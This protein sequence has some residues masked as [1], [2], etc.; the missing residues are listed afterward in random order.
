MLPVFEFHHNPRL[1]RSYPR[2]LC[3]TQ[4][5]SPVAP[6]QTRAWRVATFTMEPGQEKPPGVLES[7][8]GR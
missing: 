1:V 4:D 3:G 5:E 2:H 7:G 8:E 6:I